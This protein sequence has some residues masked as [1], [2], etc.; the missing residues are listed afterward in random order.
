[1]QR[2]RTKKRRI[3]KGRTITFVTVLFLLLVSLIFGIQKV[4]L[5]KNSKTAS[6]S[7]SLSTSSSSSSKVSST[8]KQTSSGSSSSSSNQSPLE[9]GSK[10]DWQLVLVNLKNKKPEMNPSLTTID[11][12]QMDTRIVQNVQDF[13]AAAQQI[14]SRVHL[15]S[16][17]RSVAYQTSLFNGYVQQT[18]AA[19]PG[20][21]EAEATAE[22]MKTS[23][24]PQASEHE[25]GLAMDM[26]TADELNAE[27]TATA[28]AIAKIAPD[29]GFVLR[30]PSWG[31]ASTGIDYEDWHFRY[32]GEATA[33]YMTAQN[34]TLEDFL[35]KLSK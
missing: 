21:T 19:N 2:K 11:N 8:S 26:S 31:T 33:K 24:P 4:F 20:W 22:V 30:F 16:G 34:L 15:I 17:Y 1:M 35:A 13:L 14:D 9:T 3:R 10:S 5:S 12:I 7:S 25:T 32:V 23:Q 27:D 6:T 28:A 29:Y 18:L